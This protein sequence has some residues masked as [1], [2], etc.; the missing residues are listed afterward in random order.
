MPETSV[1]SVAWN[2]YDESVLV[3][4]QRAKKR[5]LTRWTADDELIALRTVPPDFEHLRVVTDGERPVAELDEEDAVGFLPL[6]EGRTNPGGAA[7]RTRR[8]GR[9]DGHGCQRRV[10]GRVPFSRAPSVCSSSWAR[11]CTGST[12]SGGTTSTS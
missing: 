11:R 5:F 9:A 1:R 3:V 12:A 4:V 7:H 2:P 10:H 8:H 6:D